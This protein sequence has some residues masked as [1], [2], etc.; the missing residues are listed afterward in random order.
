ME[1]PVHE[2]LTSSVLFGENLQA[3]WQ[4]IRPRKIAPGTVEVWR[5]Y[6]PS[7]LGD[8]REQYET[9]DPEEKIRAAGFHKEQD[10]QIFIAGKALLRF[11]LGT[12]LNT[13]PRNLTFIRGTNKKPILKRPFNSDLNFNVSHSGQY[14]LIAVCD[15]EV[16][17][18]V[19]KYESF[20]ALKATMTYLFTKTEISFINDQASPLK[21]FYELWTRKEALL[22][23]ASIGIRDDIK[24]VPCLNGMHLIKQALLNSF[25]NWTVN[26]FYADDSYP[27]SVAYCGTN[28]KVLFKE[29]DEIK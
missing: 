16:G 18:D 22:K 11:I 14:I 10:R 5:F 27:A 13:D 26:S 1:N 28:K 8:I 21:T 15:E 25:D 6:L 9:L 2:V 3:T 24:Y 4:K 12:Y 20:K 7:F 23:A 29:L 17:V 19:E